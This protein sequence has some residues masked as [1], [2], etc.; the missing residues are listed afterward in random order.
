MNFVLRML[1]A[2]IFSGILAFTA[3]S[4]YDHEIGTEAFPE[5]TQRY[6]PYLPS[7]L[8]PIMIVMMFCIGVPKA[9]FSQTL[10]FVASFCF[11]IFLTL[12][13]YYLILSLLLP[14]LRR[15]YSARGCA[16]LWIVPNYLYIMA[17]DFMSLPEPLVVIRPG[18]V[19]FRYLVL[20]WFAGFLAV[21]GWKIIEHLRFR[22]RIL[23][24]AAPITDPQVLEVWNQEILQSGIQK[25]KFRLVSSA[26][27]QT[28]LT[29]GCFRR[30]TCV[31]LPER[32]YSP[33]E[34]ALVLRH[35][36]I[37]IC[38][39]DS[40]NK[41]FLVFCT[42]VCWFNP[43][44]WI[45]M[46]RSAEDLELSCD[47]SVLLDADDD[48]RRQYA[49]LILSTTADE[50]GFTTCLSA[51][52]SALRYRLKQI[53]RPKKARSGALIVGLAFFLLCMSC[54]YVAISF[55]ETTGKDAI[56]QGSENYLDNS[57]YRI[58]SIRYSDAQGAYLTHCTSEASLR[59]YLAAIPMSRLSGN[60][61]FDANK[62][63]IV[64]LLGPDGGYGVTLSDSTVSILPLSGERSKK[65]VYYVPSDIDWQHILSFMESSN[66]S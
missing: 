58:S 19:I 64:I 2:L 14:L 47:E 26:Q 45:A 49:D 20:I 33:D 24:D 31:V 16:M 23:C 65:I 56:F 39:E 27:V 6:Q 18:N 42:A 52:A 57:E 29:I 35:E 30:T 60:Y 15:R 3:F 5:G 10:D 41:F 38:R 21:L 53:I 25:P 51:S 36:L 59:E 48:T 4:K 62:S 13:A 34:L 50:R 40:T 12:S 54:G 22:R 61:S 43:L 17:Q 9:G 66:V 55:E 37:H 63:L 44:M 1:S 32:I 11:G 28:P 46:R 8:L 7:M